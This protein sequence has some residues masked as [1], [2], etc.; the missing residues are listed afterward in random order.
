MYARPFA[1]PKSVS[2]AEPSSSIITFEGLTSRC[3]SPAPCRASRAEPTCATTRTTSSSGS[4][5]LA[6]QPVLQRPAPHERDG[7]VRAP[8]DLPGVHDR[9]EMAVPDLAGGPGL[10]HEPAPVGLVVRELVAQD[11]QRD[12]DPVGPALGP[13]HDAHAALAEDVPQLVGAEVV[14]GLEVRHVPEDT[15]RRETE[16]PPP[17][18]MAAPMSEHTERLD[19]LAERIAAA[20]E[21]L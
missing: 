9:D 2:N 3:T 19:D 10:V 16:G 13:V 21:F 20:K 18:T 12:D 14:P 7:Q 5:A 4:G 8:V 11:L 1:S 17:G 15:G 6:S